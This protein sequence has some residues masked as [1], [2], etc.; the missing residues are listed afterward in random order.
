MLLNER[1]GYRIAPNILV[2]PGNQIQK[3][4]YRENFALLLPHD[5]PLSKKRPTDLSVLKNETFIF[6]T[7]CLRVSGM[8][9][10]PADLSGVWV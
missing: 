10:Y 2:T 6:T 8:W 4:L 9:N 5:H 1:N 3:F 7:V